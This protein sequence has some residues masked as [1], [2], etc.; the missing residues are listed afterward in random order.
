MGLPPLQAREAERQRLLRVNERHRER[1]RLLREGR[2]L[3]GTA[4]IKA[5][6][7]RVGTDSGGGGGAAAAMAAVMGNSRGGAKM[8]DNKS[9]KDLLNTL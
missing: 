7:A 8:K 4:G 6:A 5:A 2:S 1:E 3:H 9:D